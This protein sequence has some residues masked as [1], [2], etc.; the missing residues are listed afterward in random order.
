MV[1]PLVKVSNR[2]EK[3]LPW[4]VESPLSRANFLN[5]HDARGHAYAVRRKLADLL[6]EAYQA[7][8]AEGWRDAP[9]AEERL[10]TV[11]EFAAWAAKPAGDNPRPP[12]T[13]G[14]WA[15]DVL[16]L[17]SLCEHLVRRVAALANDSG[18]FA[19]GHAAGWAD[20]VAAC[21]QAVLDLFTK[22]QLVSSDTICEAI[23]GCGNAR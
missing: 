6:T 3:S 9:V 18:A 17:A 4:L 10:K 20:A 22:S 5:E 16:E 2:P 13:G 11:R 21:S 14:S 23:R 15:A 7:A 1:S 19:D 12:G 8:L